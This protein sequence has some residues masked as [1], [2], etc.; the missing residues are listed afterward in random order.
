LNRYLIASEI[1]PPN[2][3]TIR[4][5]TVLYWVA[6]LTLVGAVVLWYSPGMSSG[7]YFP[8]PVKRLPARRHGKLWCIGAS[9]HRL[10]PVVELSKEFKDFFDEP[11]NLTGFQRAFFAGLAFAGWILSFFLIAAIGGL[12]PK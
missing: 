11:R 3:H 2:F 10:L 4:D 9:L 12:M 6:G 1:S 5:G 7:S 8:S